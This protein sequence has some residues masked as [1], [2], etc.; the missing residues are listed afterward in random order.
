M[1][2]ADFKARQPPRRL[3]KCVRWLHW[4]L[5][6]LDSQSCGN[7]GP[8][9]SIQFCV[10]KV[11]VMAFQNIR[12]AFS[13]NLLSTFSISSERSK[14]LS[15]TL[16]KAFF[17][18]VFQLGARKRNYFFFFPGKRSSGQVPF[19]S[20]QFSANNCVILL[21]WS[22][23]FSPTSQ[24]ICWRSCVISPTSFHFIWFITSTFEK[25]SRA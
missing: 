24:A 12:S 9:L 4:T 7:W 10:H 11:M 3:L 2:K 21:T 20:G 6:A 1:T 19:L 16:K 18:S 8:C 22:L 23:P 17:F 13:Q 5:G 14:V 25:H 15:Y